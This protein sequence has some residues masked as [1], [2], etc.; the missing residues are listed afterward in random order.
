MQ[1]G[2]RRSYVG[3]TIVAQDSGI[4]RPPT[5]LSPQHLRVVELPAIREDVRVRVGCQREF[6]LADKPSNL[7]PRAAL[8][9][10]QADAAVPQVVWS[11]GFAQE[12]TRRLGTKNAGTGSAR[13]SGL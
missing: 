2:R 7:G 12:P 6:A 5:S 10:E 1:S 3:S 4:A 8:M 11:I 13:C 9:V